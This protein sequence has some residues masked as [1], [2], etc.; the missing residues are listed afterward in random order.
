MSLNRKATLWIA[1][2]SYQIS[3]ISDGAYAI[4]SQYASLAQAQLIPPKP[5]C[6]ANANWVKN[7]WA[8]YYERKAKITSEEVTNYDFTSLG[9]LPY[10]MNEVMEEVAT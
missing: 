6:T 10:P 7:L 8:E 3:K 4:C 9:A 2:S 1:A 5:K